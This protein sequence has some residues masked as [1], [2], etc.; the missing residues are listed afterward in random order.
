MRG[1]MD[2]LLKFKLL[3]AVNIKTFA[4]NGFWA[5]ANRP[6]A[7][8][9]AMDFLLLKYKLL[10]AVNIKTFACNGFCEHQDLCL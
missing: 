10:D 4:C 9:I 1:V 8:G 2:F 6:E 5:C 7:W 3:D